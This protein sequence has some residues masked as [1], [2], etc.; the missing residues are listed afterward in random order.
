M[1]DMVKK[2][3]ENEKMKITDDTK[4]DETRAIFDQKMV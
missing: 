4:Q 2:R 1:H 3:M